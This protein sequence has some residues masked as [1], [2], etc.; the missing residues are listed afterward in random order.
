MILPFVESTRFVAIQSVLACFSCPG[1]CGHLL[2]RNLRKKMASRLSLKYSS[3]FSH[4]LI[5]AV[6]SIFT[7]LLVRRNLCR[8]EVPE[9]P[10]DEVEAGWIECVC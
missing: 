10:D 7:F 6:S 1:G 9:V 5:S 4:I 3:I 8:V 2:G